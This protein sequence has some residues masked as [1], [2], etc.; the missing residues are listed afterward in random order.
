MISH[1]E[2]GGKLAT[3]TD[4]EQAALLNSFAFHLRIECE[5]GFMYE[6]QLCMLA[7]HLDKDGKAL[8]K[9]L[10]EFLDA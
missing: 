9:A 4:S 10:A 8:V 3:Q 5:T 1:N 6:S 2:I 7:K